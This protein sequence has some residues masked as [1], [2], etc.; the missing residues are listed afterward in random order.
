MYKFFSQ[1]GS[2]RQVNSNNFPNGE[3]NFNVI[4]IQL[5]KI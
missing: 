5:R 3:I 2:L 4:P 1:E